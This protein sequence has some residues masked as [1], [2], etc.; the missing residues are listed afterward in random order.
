MIIT[1]VNNLAQGYWLH[2]VNVKKSSKLCLGIE[3]CIDN[4]SGNL[5]GCFS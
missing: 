2:N 1:E 3:Y 5:V 4:D